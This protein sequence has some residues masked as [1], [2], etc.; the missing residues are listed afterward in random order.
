MNKTQKAKDAIDYSSM[1]DNL[2]WPAQDDPDIQYKLYKKR[3]FYINRI[4]EL[5]DIVTYEDIEKLR[6]KTCEQ[7][8]FDLTNTQKLLAS[9]INPNTPYKNLLVFHGTGVGKTLT[10]IAIADNFRELV[11]K[12]STKIYILVKGPLNKKEFLQQLVFY[13]ENINGPSKTT[14]ATPQER[15]ATN[16]NIYNII[17]QYYRFM[18]Y[19]SFHKKVMGEK[20]KQQVIVNG[21]MRTINKKL[22][23][24][25]YERYTSTDQI[26]NLDNSVLII[27]EAHNLTNNEQ[28]GGAVK[29][30]IDS[31]KN[32]RTVLLTATPMKNLADDIIELLNLIRPLDSQIDRD[33]V[34]NSVKGYL[35]D[36]SKPDPKKPNELVGKAYLAAMAR[37]YISYLEGGNPYTFATKLDVGS[38]T[39]NLSFTPVIE[40]TMMDF[41]F[42]CYKQ[43]IDNE[44]DSFDRK[45]E[46]VA[47]FAYPGLKRHQS[48][49]PPTLI[50]YHGNEDMIALRNQLKNNRDVICNL[51][52]RDILSEYNLEPNQIR[53]LIYVENKAI[54]GRIYSLKYLKHFSTK[55]HQLLTNLNRLVSSKS[56]NTRSGL[57]FIYSNLVESGIKII[58][59]ALLE[60]GYLEYESNASNYNISDGTVCY[61]CGLK[62]NE[63]ADITLGTHD[64]SDV[65]QH[66]FRPATFL[67]FVGRDNELDQESADN[68]DILKRVFNHVSNSDG[69]NIKLVIGSKVMNEGITLENIAEIYLFDVHHSLGNVDQVIG[70]GIRF[71][72]HYKI[73]NKDNPFPVV[74]VYRYIISLPNGEISSEEQLYQRAES[75]YL[76]IKKTERILIQ[77]AIDCPENYN[78]NVLKSKVQQYKNCDD[79]FYP[80]KDWSKSTRKPC[81]SSCSFMSCEF[82][83]SNPRL[84]LE[85]YDPTRNV[86][87]LLNKNEIDYVGSE[88]IKSEIRYCKNKIKEMYLLNYIYTL[89]EIVQYVRANYPKDKI[90]I[91]D[92]YYTYQALNDLLPVTDNDFN[93][94]TDVVINKFNIYGYLIYRDHYYI[95]QSFDT[96]ESLPLYYRKHYNPTIINKLSI[97]DYTQSTMDLETW[98]RV[99]SKYLDIDQ[100][101]FTSTDYYYNAKD[102]YDYVG[103]V[104][105]AKNNLQD[106]FKIRIKRPKVLEKK[107]QTGISTYK[108]A[109]CVTAKNKTFLSAVIKKLKIKTTGNRESLC[110]TIFEALFELEKYTLD[111]KTTYLI[112]PFNHPIYPF[113][114]NLQDRVTSVIKQIHR[115]IAI[116]DEIEIERVKLDE[117][118]INPNIT[119]YEYHLIFSSD[120]PDATRKYLVS[121]GAVHVDRFDE[122]G[123]KEGNWVIVVK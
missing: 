102:N 54:K 55:L 16:A 28:G 74:R 95:F 46:A 13:L 35:M 110:K 51:I 81:P 24:G 111:S 94:F 86:Y 17:N 92:D 88:S 15:A 60:N 116:R 120:V 20:V 19:K 8:N 89:I 39:K 118:T 32:L 53:E 36:F 82:K 59:E 117:S 65:D 100:Y 96:S 123:V 37:G 68:H 73:T 1:L 75:K 22:P 27:D 83:C 84:N 21:K 99:S 48:N 87:K 63:H 109:S 25:D 80:G 72:K 70:R 42:R 67:T 30:I 119:K 31:S 122:R 115:D 78:A 114:L 69:R 106:E 5:D 103:I 113:P 97:K 2:I 62:Y 66:L 41:Q 58:R 3:D 56:N 108:G 64:A 14:N 12:Y 29:Q 85:L 26:I 44:T 112:I 61:Y 121:I 93:N 107:R 45:S 105:R 79:E 11:E 9:I 33:R 4:P 23:N 34:F 101:D 91:F 6:K 50:G 10:A 38:V 98:K 18:S 43:V 57:A 47:N 49:A 71:C 52:N 40:C 104:D 7:S 90:D 76:L 77:E